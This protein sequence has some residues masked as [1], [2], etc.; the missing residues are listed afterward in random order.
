MAVSLHE[1]HL[2]LEGDSWIA[3]SSS[4]SRDRQIGYIHLFK[5]T[6]NV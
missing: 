6:E 2:S 5:K 1:N 3:A 4:C